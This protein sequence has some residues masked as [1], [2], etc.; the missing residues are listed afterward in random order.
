MAEDEERAWQLAMH[1]LEF[2]TKY[3]D[4]LPMVEEGGQKWFAHP[5]E[6]EAWLALGA[7]GISID[8]LNAYLSDFPL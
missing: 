1:H 3:D 5:M 6:F 7:P 2:L 4:T 8:E